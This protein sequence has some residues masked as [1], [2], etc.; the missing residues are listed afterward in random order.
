[1]F[2]YIVKKRI[3]CKWGLNQMHS[4]MNSMNSNSMSMCGWVWQSQQNTVYD[5]SFILGG[6]GAGHSW[7]L[8][9]KTLKAS[10]EPH[11]IA[12]FKYQ[13]AKYKTV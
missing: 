3:M 7:I 2:C 5:D 1:M 12:K 10:M 13:V 6:G 9:S 4:I 8:K 11:F